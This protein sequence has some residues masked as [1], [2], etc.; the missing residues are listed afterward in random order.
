VTPELKVGVIGCGE[1]ASG[2]FKMIEREPRMRLVAVADLDEKRLERVRAEHAPE[3]TFQDYRAMLDAIDLDAVYI[4]TM[5]MVILPIA[6]ECL[7]RGVNASV[8]K[9]AGMNS[10][11]TRQML[12]AAQASGAKAMVSF[13]RRFQPEIL[14]VR[15]LLQARGGAEHVV[16][17]FHYPS[18]PDLYRDLPDPD[19][20]RRLPPMIICAGIHHVDLLRWLAGR[21]PEEAAAVDEVFAHAWD[22]PREGTQRQNAIVR[23]D[24]DCHGAVMTHCGVGG[25]RPVEA[26]AEDLSIYFDPAGPFNMFGRVSPRMFIGGKPWEQPLDLDAVGGAGFNETTHFADCLLN[27]AKPWTSLD[28]AVKS[29]E[30][31]EAILGGHKGP[32]NA[33]APPWAAQPAQLR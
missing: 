26:H 18:L 22:G 27:G 31:C 5:P 11:E 7:D 24:T 8:E 33:W 14:A 17:N 6:L 3:Q 13:D 10:G 28:D 23:F 25:G 4:C 19:L 15:A 1:H 21:A 32:M 12:A 30:L 29:L 20:W 9:P 16:A 2:H